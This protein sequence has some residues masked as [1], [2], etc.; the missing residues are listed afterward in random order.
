VPRE[1]AD[2]ETGL[3]VDADDRGVDLLVLEERRDHPHDR[4]DADHEDVAV[5][6]GEG[7]G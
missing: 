3:V 1:H 2:R 6:R 5:V 7:L 4:A